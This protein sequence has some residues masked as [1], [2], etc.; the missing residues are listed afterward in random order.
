VLLVDIST[1]EE[2]NGMRND[3]EVVVSIRGTA[4]RA[5]IRAKD[6]LAMKEAIVTVFPERYCS[7][8]S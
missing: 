2:V 7:V 3:V 6:P 8:R 1:F 4:M 5:V